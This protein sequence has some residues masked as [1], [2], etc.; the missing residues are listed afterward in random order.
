MSKEEKIITEFCLNRLRYHLGLLFLPD[1]P[2]RVH[3]EEQ[4]DAILEDWNNPENL[5]D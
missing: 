1:N 3:L 4:I 5:T 2:I